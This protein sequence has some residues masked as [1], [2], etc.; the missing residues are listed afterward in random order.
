M[1]KNM[2]KDAWKNTGTKGTPSYSVKDEK[3][4]VKDITKIQWSTVALRD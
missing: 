1:D 3:F 2:I 4:Q